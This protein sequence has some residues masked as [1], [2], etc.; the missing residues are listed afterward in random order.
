MIGIGVDIGGTF[1]DFV[2]LDSASGR[3]AVWKQLSSPDD[4]SRTV[5]AGVRELLAEFGGELDQVDLIVHGTTLVANALIERKGARIGLVASAGHR[6]AVEIGREIRYDIYDLFLDRPKPLVER[7]LR[8]EVSGRLNANGTELVAI[9]PAQVR[10]V[11]QFLKSEGVEAVAVSLLHSYVDPAHERQVEA[12]LTDSLPGIP[13]SLSSQIAPVMREYERTSTT[14]ANAYVQ[15]LME[16]YLEKLRA[17]FAALTPR[18]AFYVMLSGGGAASI[19]E[20]RSAPI[21]LVE[22]GP[23]A[24]AIAA[25]HYSSDTP[26]RDL[27]AFDMGGTTAKVSV[28]TGGV[29]SR[30]QEMEVARHAR[31]KKGS[32]LPL[33]VPTVELIEIGA[34]GGSIARSDRL[35][36]LKVG[37]ESAGAL[38]GPA[39][40][41]LGGLR[42]TVTDANLHLGYLDP[43][44]FLGGRMELNPDAAKAALS[45]LGAG[46]HLDATG[47][48]RGIHDIVN[49]NMA[50]AARRHITEQARDPRSHTLVAFGGSGPVHAYGLARS[51]KIATVICPPAAGAASALGCLLAPITVELSRSLL[52]Q[53][54]EFDWP[55]LRSLYA[56]LQ[57]EAEGALQEAQVRPDQARVLRSAD[58]R[59]IGQG[60]ELQVEIPDAFWTGN[61][62][63][64]AAA[65]E[66]EYERRFGRRLSGIGIEIVTWRFVASGP[67]RKV[68]LRLLA[69]RNGGGEPRIGSRQVHFAESG[70][71]VEAVVYD[72]YALQPG[73]RLTGPAVVQERE[74]AVVVGPLAVAEMDGT[75]NLV[76][77]LTN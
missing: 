24:G 26:G 73:A 43:S 72:R 12:I 47:A 8:I 16:A 58:I 70:G 48:A 75:G 67:G 37:P 74:S 46:L 77:T 50:I 25:C 40:Y 34:G 41:A 28:I 1:T 3:A 56:N 2:A 76:M 15:P 38:P 69:T 13:I 65:F 27:I 22:S 52:M 63:T 68:D 53:L 71:W 57:T 62:G 59:Y 44:N 60:H 61:G 32:G 17:A 4:P 21:R 39:C 54:D 9:E 29:P 23:A 19:R 33:L 42:A 64:L 10:A 31:F 66:L 35:G 36:L 20:A 14:V 45:E 5:I 18:A 7:E 11:A 30:A 49:E 6:D 51:L 55:A